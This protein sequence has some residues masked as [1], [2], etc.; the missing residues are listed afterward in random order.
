MYT[1]PNTPLPKAV[2]RTCVIAIFRVFSICFALAVV[3]AAIAILLKAPQNQRQLTTTAQVVPNHDWKI[4][5]LFQQLLQL[6]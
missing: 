1:D 2:L 6:F 5:P 4:S 3:L